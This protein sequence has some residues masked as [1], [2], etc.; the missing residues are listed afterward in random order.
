[1]KLHLA[2]KDNFLVHN[3]NWFVH[4]SLPESRK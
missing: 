3:Y 4:N 1:V 2:G